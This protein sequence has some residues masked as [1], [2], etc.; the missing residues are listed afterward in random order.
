ML[1]LTMEITL[2][3]KTIKKESSDFFFIVEAG[4]NFYELG[5]FLGISYLDAAKLM[6]KDAALS[7]A[8]AIKFQTYFA[9]KFV[10]NHICSLD[11]YN[12]VRRHDLLTCKDFLTLKE[13]CKSKG[14][15]FIT[16]IFDEDTLETLGKE[17]EVF[18]V[19]SPDITNYRLLEKI[20]E[21]KKP[22]LLSVGASFKE[23]IDKALSMLNS[24]PVC[25]MHCNT[26]YP[27]R[28]FQLNLSKIKTLNKTYANNV[29][30]F[31][32]HSGNNHYEHII[33]AFNLGAN[34][35]EVHFKYREPYSEEIRG[36]DYPIS[37][38][39]PEVA[40]IIDKLR[41]FNITYGDNSI[42]Y[43]EKE[44]KEVR[45]NGRRSVFAKK[46][47]KK[48]EPIT[49]ENTHLLRPGDIFGISIKAEDFSKIEGKISK[50][51]IPSGSIIEKKAVELEYNL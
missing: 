38:K 9:D 1:V 14:I 6:I 23:E 35:I 34:I 8:S 26:I 40:K 18:K 15:Y 4:T 10:S 25:I 46:E 45:R 12:Y 44:E 24:C 28:E 48:G 30:G 42:D 43:F 27:T 29:I 2:F 5:D 37:I 32:C 13:Y 3:D 21:Y 22:V 50:M 51:N 33:T 17:M 47:I 16:S 36:N 7:K 20:N 19:A 39:R 31:S 11:Q 49:K 41:Y